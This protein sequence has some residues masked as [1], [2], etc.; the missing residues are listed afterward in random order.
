MKIK[1]KGVVVKDILSYYEDLPIAYL[2]IGVRVVEFNFDCDTLLARNIMI[3][4]FV[5]TQ[6]AVEK[7]DCEVY[8]YIGKLRPIHFKK[9]HTQCSKKKCLKRTKQN[10]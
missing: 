5:R 4:F 7:L 8:L 2:K 1:I 10:L 3:D 6:S 9:E